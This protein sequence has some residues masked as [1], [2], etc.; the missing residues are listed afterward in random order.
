MNVVTVEIPNYLRRVKLSEARQIKYYYKDAKTGKSSLPKAAKYKTDK[1]EWRPLKKNGLKMFLY[2][3]E[4]DE[5][6]VA[7]PKAAGTPRYMVI[8]GQKLYN[9]EMSKFTRSKIINAIK[10]EI[11]SYTDALDVITEFPLSIQMEIHD[12][13]RESNSKAL[14][15]VDNRA[16]PYIKAFQD[17]LTG[18]K[19]KNGNLRCK[20]VIPDDNILFIPGPPSPKFIPVDNEDAR[21][22]VFKI[23]KETDTRIINNKNYQLELKSE[24][25]GTQ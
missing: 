9:G 20:Q 21:K 10:D 17:C 11:S 22:L 16:G 13:I 12:T 1:Y 15:D 18:N 23:V 25:H 2:S 14:W 5:R 6:V 19:D 7:N 3:K 8:N 24:L 4:T